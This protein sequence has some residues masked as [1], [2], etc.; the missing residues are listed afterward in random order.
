MNRLELVRAEVD[1]I[2][3][4]QTNV[5]VRRNG[6]IH[7]Y[8]VAQI[9]SLLAIKRGL[10]IELCTITG[11]LHD[12]Y[13]YQFEYVK[14]HALLGATQAEFLLKKLD[15]FTDE[16]IEII[17]N[18]IRNHSD[19][20]TKQDK[21]SELIK[22]ADVLHSLLYNTAFEIKHKKRVKKT[23]KNFGIKIKLKKAKAKKDEHVEE[24]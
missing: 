20:K 22:D 16:E 9:C 4:N 11:M 2:L 23:F 24:D 13:S 7:L 1:A 8:G 14:D 10:D 19:K 6:F 18:S 17:T 12:I 15:I 5:E 21:Y 3:L